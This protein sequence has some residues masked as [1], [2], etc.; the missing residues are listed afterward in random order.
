MA[1]PME[2]VIIG[3]P[4]NDFTGEIAPELMA[5]VDRGAIRIVDLLFVSK[6]DDGSTFVIEVDEDERLRAFVE[7]DGE[8]GGVISE[9]DV[10]HAAASVDAG[11][12]VLVI[13]WE[14]LW[15]EPLVDAMRRAGGVLIEG[16]RIPAELVDE[17]HQALASAG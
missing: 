2:Y 14:D 7:I 17:V 13:V 4:D 12:S 10:E 8:V 16:A 5:L 15:A 1:P 6:N 11:S 3:F 9:A